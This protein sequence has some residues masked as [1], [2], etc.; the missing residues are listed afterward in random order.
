MAWCARMNLA[1]GP[2]DGERDNGV[3]SMEWDTTQRRWVGG[4]RAEMI[5]R[6]AN[7]STDAEGDAGAIASACGCS[8]ESLT[9]SPPAIA[10]DFANKFL[11]GA[12]FPQLGGVAAD[13][14]D[15]PALIA[16]E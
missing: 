6:L 9:V 10:Y 2:S 4:D 12:Y 5:R 3:A 14:R 15:R 11:D 7:F 8:A 16:V 1:H 13:P